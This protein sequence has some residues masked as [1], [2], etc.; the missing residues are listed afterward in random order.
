MTGVM[1]VPDIVKYDGFSAGGDF[2]RSLGRL[3]FRCLCQAKSRLLPVL[4]KTEV[5]LGVV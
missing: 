5:F 3:S 2:N 1:P 4:H